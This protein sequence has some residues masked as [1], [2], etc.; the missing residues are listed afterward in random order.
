[1][2]IGADGEKRLIMESKGLTDSKAGL[3]WDCTRSSCGDSASAQLKTELAHDIGQELQP[4][5]H[6]AAWF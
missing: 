4:L 3:P 6:V 1:M 2:V 5:C